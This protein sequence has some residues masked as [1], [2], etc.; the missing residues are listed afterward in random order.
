[1]NRT[2]HYVVISANCH[3]GA[4]HAWVRLTQLSEAVEAVVEDDGTGFDI[5]ALGRAEF[6]RFGLATMRERA[7]SVGGTLQ[8]DSVPGRGTRVIARF[9]VAGSDRRTRPSAE[10]LASPQPDSTISPSSASGAA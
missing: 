10:R 4:S 5:E 9:P 1:M 2:D 8:I 6:P 7:E 3:A